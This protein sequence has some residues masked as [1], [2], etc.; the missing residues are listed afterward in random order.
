MIFWFG[1]WASGFRFLGSLENF[2]VKEIFWFNQVY[3]LLGPKN[4]FMLIWPMW[5]Q[6]R[7][8]LM[9]QIVYALKLKPHLHNDDDPW[10]KLALYVLEIALQLQHWSKFALKRQIS[11]K[12]LWKVQMSWA[13]ELKTHFNIYDDLWKKI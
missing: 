12:I 10:K 2:F 7:Y 5:Y 3:P 9:V 4:D 6:L 11:V 1:I 13:L 8:V